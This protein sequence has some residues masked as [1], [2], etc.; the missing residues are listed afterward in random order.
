MPSSSATLL[1]S[2]Q[3]AARLRELDPHNMMGLVLNFAAQCREAAEIGKALQ[4]LPSSS[5]PITNV[6]VCALGGSAI[7]ADF[8]RS[9]IDAY[10]TVPL[11]V[12]R[13]YIIPHW[14]G[15]GT[16][17]ITA[18]YSGNT[19]ETLACYAAARAS[20]AQIAAI[21]SGGALRDQAD[22]D[23]YPV[24]LVP[25]GQPPRSA[26]GY[27]FFPLL[28][29]LVQRGLLQ[30]DMT[31]DISESLALLESQARRFGPTVPTEQNPAK[32]LAIA[33]YQ[34]LPV[35][36][37]S[38]GYRGV[39]AIRWKGQFNENAKQAAFAN[40]LP[41]QNHNEI[42]AWHLATTQAKNWITLF[43]RDPS[44][45]EETPR[46]ARR[47]EVTRDIIGDASEVHEVWAEG[48]SLLARILTLAHF[49]DYL[50]VY[51]AILNGVCPTDIGSIDRLKTELAKL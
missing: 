40:V 43:L 39:V 34:K 47:V 24:A 30:H 51:L 41:E 12:N 38:Q 44:E 17:L 32:Q 2:L 3:D 49:A 31:P 37:G 35:L 15:P 46:I 26:T 14:V 7:G 1:D 11:T 27:M 36:Y 8:A 45:K 25:G 22:R 42:L 13:D 6:V 29:F 5:E 20:G 23:H 28:G 50:T 9:L 48:A 18:S 4:A 21:T 10:G 19:E 33:C 16:L